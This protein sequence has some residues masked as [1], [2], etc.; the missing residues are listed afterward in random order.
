[1]LLNGLFS[2]FTYREDFSYQSGLYKEGIGG[3]VGACSLL[4]LLK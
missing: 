1:L 3:V 2:M 4:K